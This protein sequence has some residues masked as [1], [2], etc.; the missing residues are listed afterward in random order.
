M[1]SMSNWETIILFFA[2]KN[3]YSTIKEIVITL[4]TVYI[5]TFTSELV[6]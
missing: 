5:Y 6:N 1:L 3:T 2:K 4:P